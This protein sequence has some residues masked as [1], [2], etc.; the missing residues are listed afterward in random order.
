MNSTFG[1]SETGFKPKDLTTIKHDIETSMLK[2]IDPGLNLGAGSIAGILSAIVANQTCQ[3][4]EA[5][6]GLYHSLQPHAATGSALDALC[7]LTGT[8]RQQAQKTVVTATLTLDPGIT[9]PK[10]SR[11][12]TVGDDMFI[13]TH[14]VKNTARIRQS[15]DVVVIAEDTGP[16]MAYA[17]TEAT[18]MTPVAGWLKAVIKDMQRPG[19]HQESD[20]DLRLRRLDEI[21]ATG[22]STHHALRSRLLKVRGV[23]AVY[24]K[25]ANRSFE[26]I[27]HGGDDHDIAQTIWLTKPLGVDTAGK[28]SCSIR[29]S[30][31]Q[32]RIIRFSR[33][34]V[35]SLSLQIFLKVQKTLDEAVLTALKNTVADFAQSYF[36]MGAEIYASRFVALLAAQPY[37]LD[38]TSLQ[39]TTALSGTPPP[40]V[41]KPD[42]IAVLEFANIHIKATVEEAP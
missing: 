5:L 38:V 4:W 2:D 29:D 32:E 35:I 39:F 23:Q 1:L 3:V 9:V 17:N 28:T 6:L 34:E 11:I 7:S 41:I 27:V 33:P 22:S 12:K 8:Y 24:I 31:E 20:L 42:Q 40:A 36:V 16:I 21:K 14:D 30:F 13:T 37:I 18:I 15:V 26:A 10:D 19:C 25:E